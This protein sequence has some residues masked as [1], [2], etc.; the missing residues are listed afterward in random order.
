MEKNLQKLT[1]KTMKKKEY[2]EIL[3]YL[4][5]DPVYKKTNPCEIEVLEES[6]CIIRF[7]FDRL[8]KY[9]EKVGLWYVL[10]DRCDCLY[11]KT[12]ALDKGTYYL[13]ST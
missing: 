3:E 11:C 1:N 2:I 8:K 10:E 12:E 13:D 7:M 9:Y 6:S 4:Y 5:L